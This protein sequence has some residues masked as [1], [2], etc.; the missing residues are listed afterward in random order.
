MI[1]PAADARQRG[2]GRGG[3]GG[4]PLTLI[5][6]SNCSNPHECSLS[7]RLT[8][9]PVVVRYSL[10]WGVSPAVV[11]AAFLIAIRL[12]KGGYAKSTP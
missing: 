1:A 3:R 4:G 12:A 8:P 11:Q 6:T 7:G 10:D 2:R 5:H 9:S